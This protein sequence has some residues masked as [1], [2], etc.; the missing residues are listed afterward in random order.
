[1]IQVTPQMRV[2]V[3][4]APADFRRGID[5]LA[6]QCRQ[7]LQEDPFS[8]TIFVFRNRRGTGIKILVYDGQ[9]FWLCYKRLSKSRFRWLLNDN[10]NWALAT[11]ITEHS[12]GRLLA[13]GL[14]PGVS[15]SPEVGGGERSESPKTG[16]EAETPGAPPIP[17]Q[18][19]AEKRVFSTLRIGM[20]LAE[21]RVTTPLQRFQGSLTGNGHGYYFDSALSL[22]GSVFVS[23]AFPPSAASSSGV[24]RSTPL[25]L[26][27]ASS[28]R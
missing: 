28:N 23:V 7:E 14:P 9:G 15:A 4:V 8:G 24:L 22:S 11:T 12:L 19:F 10:Y 13:L 27:S 5:G 20:P 3:A 1:M 16:G 25:F 18:K 17:L 6:R 2:L 26:F 21:M